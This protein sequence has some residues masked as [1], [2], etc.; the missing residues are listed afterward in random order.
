M[1]K[2]NKS[3]KTALAQDNDA[4]IAKERVAAR[5][6]KVEKELLFSK[7]NYMIIGL[8]LVMVII[9]FFLMSGGHNESEEWNAEVI[10][11]FVRITISPLVILGG[12]GVVIFA[13]FKS[14]DKEVQN[15]EA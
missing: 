13:I 11:S 8:G 12:L 9:G 10:Y 3:G 1:A 4:I 5:K 14:S 15:L 7:T 2:G 6:G